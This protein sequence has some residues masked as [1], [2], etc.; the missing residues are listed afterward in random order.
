[1][2]SLLFF[3]SAMLH[4]R[5]HDTPWPYIKYRYKSSEPIT[6]GL[7]LLNSRMAFLKLPKLEEGGWMPRRKWG[8]VRN[9]CQNDMLSRSMFVHSN[10]F[11]TIFGSRWGNDQLVARSNS[12]L[13][14]SRQFI[15]SAC[16]PFHFCPYPQL[17]T[18]WC[19]RRPAFSAHWNSFSSVLCRCTA[20]FLPF[21]LTIATMRGIPVFVAILI[22]LACSFVQ[23]LGE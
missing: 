19:P 2:R 12:V 8:C 20:R 1:M 16:Y 7:V 11:Y 14:A 3:A 5:T 15:T 9:K 4:S 18:N 17:H 6:A 13:S 21:G 23:S 22:G 10:A